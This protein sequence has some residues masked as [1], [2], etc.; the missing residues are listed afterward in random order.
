MVI[1]DFGSLGDYT[2]IVYFEDAQTKILDNP[3]S[4]A[5]QRNEYGDIVAVKT[6]FFN[7]E[8]T[9]VRGLDLSFNYEKMFTNGQSFDLNINATYLIDYL[10][11]EHN[12]ESDHATEH[13]VNRAGRFNYNA[14]THS[15]PV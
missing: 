9:I 5:I 8:K 6:T 12:D 2:K 15:L 10:T 1:L 11:P 13:M 7:E 14:H 4:Q 3:N